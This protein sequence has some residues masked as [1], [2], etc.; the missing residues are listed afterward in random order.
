MTHAC[1]KC[2]NWGD[3]LSY[4]FG[5]CTTCWSK[6]I[7]PTGEI[8][9]QDWSKYMETTTNLCNRCGKTGTKLYSG[10][11]HCWSKEKEVAY[12]LDKLVT[13]KNLVAKLD[14]E[15]DDVR[16]A[17]VTVAELEAQLAKVT[18]QVTLLKKYARHLNCSWALDP[19]AK[20]SCGFFNIY[21]AIT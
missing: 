8:V 21:N 9:S 10:C 7:T 17:P 20:C 18:Q 11:Q 1:A 2:G 16:K 3:A 12:L 15:L 4:L 6:V 19:E 14:K 13:A 5:F